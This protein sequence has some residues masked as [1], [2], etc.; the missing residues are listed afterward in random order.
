MAKKF[1]TTLETAAITKQ[2]TSLAGRGKAW[3]E[4]VQICA[5]NVLGHLDKHGDITLVNRLVDAMPAGARVNALRSWFELSTSKVQYN[6][7]TKQ[8]DFVKKQDPVDMEGAAAI[9]WYD[10][11]PE[12]EFRPF[13]LNAQIQALIKKAQKAQ[14]SDNADLHSIDE[15]QL[16]ALSTLVEVK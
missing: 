2:I 10:C 6:E 12:P 1:A 8:F 7:E 11:K 16:T 4:D 5:L 14:S 9:N 3:Q 15:A 13:D